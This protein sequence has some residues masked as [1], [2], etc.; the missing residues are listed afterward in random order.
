MCQSRVNKEVEKVDRYSSNWQD[1][2]SL[3][4]H[5]LAEQIYEYLR[6]EAIKEPRITG[7]VN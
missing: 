3:N 4:E 6:R 2:I 5:K 1:N 7:K